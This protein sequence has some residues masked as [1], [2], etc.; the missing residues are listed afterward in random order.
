MS[1]ST[2]RDEAVFVAVGD[3]L[4]ITDGLASSKLRAAM[5]GALGH[6]QRVQIHEGVRD[7]LG[8]PAVRADFVDQKNRPGELDSLYF[9]P[10]T[11]QLL[12]ERNGSSGGPSDPHAYQSTSYGAMGAPANTQQQLVGPNNANVM[13]SEKVV[14]SLP[15]SVRN[16]PNH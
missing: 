3:D 14:G 16:C 10:A 15:S 8:R 5:L 7:V 1:G 12:A 13:T 2:S 11:F 4:R 9:D 6:V